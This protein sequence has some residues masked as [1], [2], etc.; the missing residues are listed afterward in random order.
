MEIDTL[1]GHEGNA[2]RVY[3]AAMVAVLGEAWPFAKR[4][5]QPARDPVSALLNFGYSLLHRLVVLHLVRRQLSPN[6]GHLHVP[7]PGHAALASDLMEE[8][9]APLVDA[10]VVDLALNGMWRAKDFL[11]DESGG[12]W[13]P[14]EMRRKFIASWEAALVRPILH[15]HAKRAMDW[16]RIIEYQV[17]HYAR[18]L[19]GQDPVYRPMLVR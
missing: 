16:Q 14:L 15:P 13:I 17:Q 7:K 8:L 10:L 5:R 9:R 11:S 4:T 19:Q 12:V 18:V 6:L 1:R 3:F 2:A